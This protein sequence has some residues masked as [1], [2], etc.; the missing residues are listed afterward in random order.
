MSYKITVIN[1]DTGEVVVNEENVKVIL[2]AITTEENT[3]VLVQTAAS[4]N[5][6]L[7]AL[8]GVEE[9]KALLFTKFPTL[10][11]IDAFR[12]FRKET[13]DEH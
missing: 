6:I 12:T 13:S 8:D 5:E 11:L 2:G 7:N 4:A 1:N 3:G 10:K 9:S